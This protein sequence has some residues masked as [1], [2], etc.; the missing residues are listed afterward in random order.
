MIDL[1]SAYDV[2]TAAEQ[3]MQ[4]KAGEI[5]ALLDQGTEESKQQALAL[6]ESLEKLQADYKEKKALYDKLVEVNTPDNVAKNFVPVSETPSTPEAD[7]PKDVMTLAEYNKLPPQDR[8]AF[9]KR[10]GKLEN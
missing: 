5:V 8:L 2:V 1:K 4:S 10:G 9:A 7:K 6:H 3:A